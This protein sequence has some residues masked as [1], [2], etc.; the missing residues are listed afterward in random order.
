MWVNFEP[1]P[2]NIFIIK[3]NDADYYSLVKEEVDY[4][5]TKTEALK[6][7]QFNVNDKEIFSNSMPWIIDDLEDRIETALGMEHLTSLDIVNL[8]SKS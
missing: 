7:Y 3:V 5:P 8:N 4:D 6:L 1:L 2:K